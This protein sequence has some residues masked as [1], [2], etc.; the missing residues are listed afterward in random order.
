MNYGVVSPLKDER[1]GTREYRLTFKFC[2]R[3]WT[4]SSRRAFFGCHGSGEGNGI[5]GGKAGGTPRPP[6]V[7]PCA[8]V[9]LA[10]P[11]RP[12]LAVARSLRRRGLAHSAFDWPTCRSR[13]GL[14]PMVGASEE[15]LLLPSS[16]PTFPLPPN[17]IYGYHVSP[18]LPP[19]AKKTV[20]HWLPVT[21]SATHWSLVKPGAPP[22]LSPGSLEEPC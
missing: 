7:P 16:D 6:P 17:H 22:S 8:Q 14:A 19:L 15:R 13:R 3:P 20:G 9:T 11:A 4:F 12:G 18:R 1:E 5:S 21:K 2:L 10:S